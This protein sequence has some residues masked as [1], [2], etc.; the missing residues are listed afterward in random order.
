MKLFHIAKYIKDR[1]MKILTRLSKPQTSLKC[2]EKIKG[3]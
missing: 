3:L 2:I 1:F